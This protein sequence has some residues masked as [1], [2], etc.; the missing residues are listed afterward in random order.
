MDNCR[1]SRANTCQSRKVVFIR[2]TEWVNHNNFANRCRAAINHSSFC[3]IMLSMVV[4]WTT[5]AL[6]GN[7]ELGF[8]P[9]EGA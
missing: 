5:M 4:Y 6:T 9:G 3:P 8:D 2:Y 7:G 1:K